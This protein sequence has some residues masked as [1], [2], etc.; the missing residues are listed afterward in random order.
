MER[1]YRRVDLSLFLRK[2][3]SWSI[4]VHPPIGLLAAIV[5]ILLGLQLLLLYGKDSYL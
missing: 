4:A 3:R 1:K 5:E 2:I